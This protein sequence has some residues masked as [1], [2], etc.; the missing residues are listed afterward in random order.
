[1]VDKCAPGFKIRFIHAVRCCVCCRDVVMDD[2]V[3][4]YCD[5]TTSKKTDQNANI[6]DDLFLGAE[7]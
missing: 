4:T 7:G 3:T 5:V 2:K 1:M 6:E